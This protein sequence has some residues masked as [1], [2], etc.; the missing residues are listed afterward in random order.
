[1]GKLLNNPAI[2]AYFNLHVVRSLRNSELH[3]T[4]AKANALRQGHRQSRN[5]I[6]ATYGL[7]EYCDSD[8][9]RWYPV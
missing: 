2:I 4:R 3:S 9:A 8:V 1:M 7:A 5:I 6:S